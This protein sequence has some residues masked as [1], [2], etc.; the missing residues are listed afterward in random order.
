MKSLFQRSIIFNLLL[1]AAVTA[2]LVMAL[3][4]SLNSITKHGMDAKVPNV[5]GLKLKEA[6][7]KLSGFEIKIDS[8]YLPY[9]DPLEIVLQDPIAENIVKEGRIIYLTVNKQTPPT[10]GMPALVNMSFRN[11]VLTL[12][13]YRLVMGDTVFKPDI[14]AGAVLEQLINGKQIAAGMNVP[15]GSRVDLVVGAGLSDSSMQV[16]D[17]IGRSFAQARST[18][19]AM[20]VL[21][22]VVWDGSISDSNS[23]VVYNQAPE[24]RN[25][26]DFNNTITPGD[27]VDIRIMQRPS[28]ELLRMNQAGSR[29][30]ID[31]NDSNVRISYG[32]ATNELPHTVEGLDANGNPITPD[33]AAAAAAA[34]S[35]TGTKIRVRKKPQTTK[36]QI[37][38]ILKDAGN[39]NNNAPLNN[40]APQDKPQ[41]F[42]GPKQDPPAPPKKPIDNKSPKPSLKQ[43]NDK[44]SKNPKDKKPVDSKKPADSKNTKDAGDKKKKDSPVKNKNNNDFSDEFK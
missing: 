42:V 40:P 4:F 17:L 31:P 19:D 21:Y 30:F 20:G 15:V 16:P 43:S 10:I 5:T 26:L 9:K 14:A 12:Q 38:D 22:N 35:A 18:L 23:A 44:T 7:G 11:A 13:S 27:M 1:M 41:D 36:Q 8:V 34:A 24:S 33:A 6:I 25:E 37:D 2:I 32:P 39:T 28:A 29:K 3:L